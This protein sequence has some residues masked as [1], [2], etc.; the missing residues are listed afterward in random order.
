MEKESVDHPSHYQGNE[1]EV[2]DI[3]EDYKL[4]FNRGNVVKYVLRA[5]KKG[6]E[7]EDYK[8]A[9][10]YLKRQIAKREKE[11]AEEKQL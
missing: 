9:I 1:F 10:F 3:I 8:K 2:I 7:I 4:G 11:L 5:R 6:S